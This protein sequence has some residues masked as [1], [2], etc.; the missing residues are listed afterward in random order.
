MLFIKP[1]IFAF[2]LEKLKYCNNNVLTS[3]THSGPF[4]K[5]KFLANHSYL[6]IEKF[7]YTKE[8][9]KDTVGF[10]QLISTFELPI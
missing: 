7:L 3:K 9:W 5:D 4:Q 10:R 6:P 2:G 1:E 8:N